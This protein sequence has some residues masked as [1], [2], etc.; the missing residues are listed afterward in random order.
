M[1]FEIIGVF[2]DIEGEQGLKI[3]FE[4]GGLIGCG[5]DMEGIGGIAGEPCIARAEH[6]EGGGGE[7][8]LE[9]I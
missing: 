3:L 1:V 5:D 2:P 4:W 8:C 7:G 6:A 9:A